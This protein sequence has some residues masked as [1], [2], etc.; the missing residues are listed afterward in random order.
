MKVNKRGERDVQTQL[1]HAYGYFVIISI[2]GSSFLLYGNYL[3]MDM[4]IK[5]LVVEN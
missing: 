2:L 4:Q 1:S 5:V 3:L